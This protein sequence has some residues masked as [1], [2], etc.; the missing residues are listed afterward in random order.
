MKI[1]NIK[2]NVSLKCEIGEL[3]VKDEYRGIGYFKVSGIYKDGSSGSDDAEH[4]RGMMAYAQERY[5]Y[6]LWLL[7]LSELKY[8]W[9]D[10]IDLILGMDELEEIDSVAIVVGSECIEAIS[11]LDGL[12]NPPEYCLTKEGYYDNISDAYEYLL[13]QYT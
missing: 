7:D 5:C 11:T 1:F 12:L 10:D 9:G 13:Q 2:E 6:S 4:A 3:P 8:D